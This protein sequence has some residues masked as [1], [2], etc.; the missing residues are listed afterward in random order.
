M[1][2]YNLILLSALATFSIAYAGHPEPKYGKY[3]PKAVHKWAPPAWKASKP[4]KW[5]Q[6]NPQPGNDSDTPKPLVSAVYE[7]ALAT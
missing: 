6:G 2:T 3:K 7:T 4:W 5:P 1:K